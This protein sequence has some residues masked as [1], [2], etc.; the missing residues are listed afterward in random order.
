MC[1][2]D[3]LYVNRG[4]TGAIVQRQPFGGWKRSAVGAG[5]KAGGPNYLFGL[6]EWAPAE[7]PAAAPGAAVNP[8]VEAVLS[9]AA[10]DLG[11][12]E[13]EWLHRAAASD[14]RAWVDEFGA[15]SDKSGLGV[16]RN[17]FRYRP[18]AVD[19]RIAEDAPL[20]DG[21]RVI[22]AALRSGS[23][24][25]VSASALPSRVEKALRAQ[26]VTPKLE[27]DAAWVKRYAK[28]AAKAEHSWQ[29]VRLVGGDAAALF[30][31]LGG[32]PDVAVWSHAVTGAGRVEMLPFLHEQAVSITNHRFGNPTTLSDGLI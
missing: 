25:T 26:G 27:N 9:A 15:V 1:I 30:E 24:F 2:R 5:A 11:A 13:I 28:A 32:T 7:L 31:A 22:A 3:S 14:E 4:I 16:E 8:S 6:G 17:V 10:S 18:V 20:A 29:R 19:V 23:P 21:I 12:V